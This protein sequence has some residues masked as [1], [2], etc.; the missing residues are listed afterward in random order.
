MLSRRDVDPATGEVHPATTAPYTRTPFRI[1]DPTSETAV[2][3]QTARLDWIASVSAG[4]KKKETRNG[5]EI[6]YPVVSRDGTIY[7]SEADQ[8]KA[9]GLAAALAARGG[10]SLG[11][12]FTS[13]NLEEVA[14]Q[15]L[16]AYTAGSVK[17]FGDDQALTEVTLQVD[18]RGRDAPALF[19]KYPVGSPDFARLRKMCKA[20]THII[21]I[22]VEW[23]GTTP[24]YAFPDYWPNR[25]SIRFTGRH[26]ARAIIGKLEQILDGTGGRLA[27][28]PFELNLEYHDVLGPDGKRHKIPVWALNMRIPGVDVLK[29]SFDQIREFTS[30]QLD[31]GRQLRAL[32]APRYE[33]EQALLEAPLAV[34]DEAAEPAPPVSDAA[35]DAIMS[36][37]PCAEAH[38]RAAFFGAVHGTQYDSDNGRAELVGEYTMATFQDQP[39]RWTESLASFLQG[40]TVDAIPPATEREASGFIAWVGEQLLAAH[41]EAQGLPPTASQTAKAAGESSASSDGVADAAAQDDATPARTPDDVE[42]TSP[43]ALAAPVADTPPH[44]DTPAAGP[45]AP[46][47]DA[48]V[49]DAQHGV[50]DVQSPALPAS[51]A[52]VG[53]QTPAADNPAPK[54]RARLTAE[55][56]YATLMMAA[57]RLGLDLATYETDAATTD[58]EL[59]ALLS[60]LAAAVRIATERAGGTQ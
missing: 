43:A 8:K 12:A 46:Q 28:L 40:S 6:E 5:K 39:T 3:P 14:L 42:S 30:T 53:S 34:D 15:R 41:R 11:I 55:A 13:D 44:S 10:K 33:I 51:D 21:F 54:S 9:P 7:M 4:Y 50:Q 38:Y 17:V 57:V 36:D 37:P 45:G 2:A 29:L 47:Q 56:N 58:D 19:T 26:S 25:Y 48:S 1:L 49:Q 27:G 32:P 22:L 23:D 20:E 24:Q 16:V 35:V 31:R 52:D 60:K 59:N 18:D